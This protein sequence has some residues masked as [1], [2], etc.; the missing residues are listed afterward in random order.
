MNAA[1]RPIQNWLSE[2]DAVNVPIELAVAFIQSAAF[3]KISVPQLL[4]L[5]IQSW[6]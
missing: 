5:I 1:L 3:N 6:G 4:L 2:S